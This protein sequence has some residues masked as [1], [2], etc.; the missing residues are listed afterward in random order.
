MRNENEV[1][2]ESI[3]NCQD[4]EKAFVGKLATS[5]A[6]PGH[7]AESRADPCNVR[8]NPRGFSSEIEYFGGD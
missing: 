4:R 7:D 5:G 2:A 8:G 1:K 3:F 6:R